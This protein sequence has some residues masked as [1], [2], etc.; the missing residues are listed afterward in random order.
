MCRL[1]RDRY[2]SW[3]SGDSVAELSSKSI[4]T[5]YFNGGTEDK[6]AYELILTKQIECNFEGPVS[7][8]DRP[9]VRWGFREYRGLTQ[10]QRFIEEY[11]ESLKQAA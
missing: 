4:P 9:F 2:I 6:E 8:Y 10:I 11:V 5:L 1:C 7:F 3:E